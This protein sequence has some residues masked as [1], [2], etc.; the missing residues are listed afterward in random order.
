MKETS[1]ERLGGAHTLLN[2]TDHSETARLLERCLADD[3][4]VGLRTPEMYGA[5]NEQLER[6]SLISNHAVNYSKQIVCHRSCV[7]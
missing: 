2:Q 4:A 5:L 6:F 3:M 1:S 7:L